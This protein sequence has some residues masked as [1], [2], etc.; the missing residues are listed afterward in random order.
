MAR[1]KDSLTVTGFASRRLIELPFTREFLVRVCLVA[2]L[3]VVSHQPGWQWL[4][5]ATSEAILR[6]SALLDMDTARLSYDTIRVQGT[7]VEFVVSC[8]FVD[9]FFG[10]L[11]LLWD[12]RRSLLRNAS[13]LVAAGAILFAFNVLR[14]E[15]AQLVY[16]RGAS[17]QV[18]DGVLGGI[19]YFCVWLAIWRLRSWDFAKLKL[20][21]DPS[22]KLD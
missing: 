11:P 10:S 21:R 17:W 4:R 20:D 16:V 18:A 13:R 9:V 8:T 14:L 5:L 19:A 1:Q 7:E 3:V 6:L 15:I 22:A 2:I 12:L